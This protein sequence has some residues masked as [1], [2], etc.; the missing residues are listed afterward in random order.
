MNASVR[1][2]CHRCR[3]VKLLAIQVR[4]QKGLGLYQVRYKS[5]FPNGYLKIN[6]DECRIGA[7]ESGK[8]PTKARD[9][10][11]KSLTGEVRDE[12]GM[13]GRLP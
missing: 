9:G 3:E 4:V 8:C 13:E 2:N 12:R 1:D 7:D 6:A 11:K 10:Q 5:Q